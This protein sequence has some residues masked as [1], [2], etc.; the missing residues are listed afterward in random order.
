MQYEKKQE[1]FIIISV[2]LLPAVS[3]RF[4]KEKSP[5]L[6]AFSSDN[7]IK[8][9]VNTFMAATSL[10]YYL[11]AEFEMNLGRDFFI[12]SLSFSLGVNTI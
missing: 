7:L 4:K 5:Q 11:K 12:A 6:T 9:R 3:I 1:L 2:A 8:S 10:I